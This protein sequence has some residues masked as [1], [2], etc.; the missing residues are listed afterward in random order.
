MGLCV[1]NLHHLRLHRLNSSL[2]NSSEDWSCTRDEFGHIRL[3]HTYCLKHNLQPLPHYLCKWPNRFRHR[4][5]RVQAQ[6]LFACN[7][8]MWQQLSQN[9][10]W[11]ISLAFTRET[12]QPGAS[13]PV[14][15]CAVINI[16]LFH[17]AGFGIVFTMFFFFFLP[18]QAGFINQSSCSKGERRRDCTVSSL[19][20]Q[21]YSA[22]SC[23]Y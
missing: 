9:C 8:T 7:C 23:F 2:A 4:L 21:L 20:W 11:E 17:T 22:G 16:A 3:S 14:L 10:R 5:P 19:R 13:P 18:K 15:G 1:C 12:L 6:T